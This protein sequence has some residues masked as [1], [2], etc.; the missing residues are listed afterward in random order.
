M[1]LRMALFIPFMA[2]SIVHMF[3]IFFTHSFVD[4]YLGCFHVLAVVD[5]LHWALGCMYPFG[6]CFSPDLCP[7]EGLQD[8]TQW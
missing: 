4:G 6:S 8:P 2:E 3:H 1:L 5:V 7:G